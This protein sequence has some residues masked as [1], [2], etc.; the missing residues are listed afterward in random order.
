MNRDFPL[1]TTASQARHAPVLQDK[2]E[3]AISRRSGLRS[4]NTDVCRLVN[5]TG[6]GLDG[7]IID[8]FGGRWLVSSKE[9]E[10]RPKLPPALGYRALYA[11]T[12]S[13]NEKTRPSYIG[14]EELTARFPILEDGLSYWI[15]FQSG[16]SQGLFID[17]RLNRRRLRELCPGKTVL[18][19]FAYTCSFGVAA[20]SAGANAVNLDLSRNYLE[21]G[22]QNYQLNG[23]QPQQSDFVYG[24]V[25]DWMARFAKRG[26]RFDIVILDPPTFSRSRASGVFRAEK[27]YV[28]LL[29]RALRVIEPS[30]TILCCLNAHHIS[31]GEFRYLLKSSLPPSA[32]LLQMPMPE[33]FPGSDYL[34]SFWVRV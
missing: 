19:T 25:F 8:D 22:Q 27:D 4:P 31:A 2:I 10:N 17:Q 12:L 26:R 21:W 3:A 29:E 5:G 18:N 11:K 32:G 34:K 9:G 33:D 15:D 14:G 1:L 30:G 28:A 24:D 16:Y 6:D 23:L 7:I 20:V 13:K